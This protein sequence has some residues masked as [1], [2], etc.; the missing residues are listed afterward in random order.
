MALVLAES[1]EDFQRFS[2]LVERG[3]AA[4]ETEPGLTAALIRAKPMTP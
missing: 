4:Y 1:P 3:L 2:Q